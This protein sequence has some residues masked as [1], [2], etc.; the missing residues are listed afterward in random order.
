MMEFLRHRTILSSGSFSSH[1]SCGSHNLLSS[2]SPCHTITLIILGCPTQI[3]G[4]GLVVK[5]VD[6]KPGES[7]I[8]CCAAPGGKT[9][10]MAS[11]LNGQGTRLR[12]VATDLLKT[13]ISEHTRSFTMSVY[14]FQ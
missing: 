6:P 8:D 1:Y 10:F 3:F 14:L 2:T 7:I 5:V 12:N 13:M 11:C 4:A 9:L